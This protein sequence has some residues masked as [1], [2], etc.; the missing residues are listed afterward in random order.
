MV[1]VERIEEWRGEPIVD[2]AG[3]QLGKLDEVFFDAGTGQALLL[4]VRSGLL[5]RH[6]RLL[7]ID[8]ATV[9]RTYLRL[10]YTKEQVEA[11]AEMN[12]E[13]TIDD[14]TL[15]ALESSY[16]I[17]LPAEL[18]L[19]SATEMEAHRAE[20]QAASER[21]DALERDAQAKLAQHESAKQQAAGA[22]TTAEAAERAAAEA[23]DAALKARQ[24]AD[25]YGG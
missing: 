24:Q 10:P 11:S 16:G 13:G 6:S 19:W 5:G 20:A 9:S 21:A 18:E 12:G 1:N 8:G 3:E 14:P 17:K 7:P 2:S 22:A 15:A 23:R 25:Q 4:S